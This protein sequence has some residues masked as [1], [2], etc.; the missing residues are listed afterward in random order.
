ME[1]IYHGDFIAKNHIGDIDFTEITGYA[2][3]T[4]WEG[5]AP[6]L[7]T[8]GGS[9]YF[10][11]WEGSAPKL[12]EKY[13]FSGIIGGRNAI[14]KFDRKDKKYWAGCFSGTGTE[15]IS[16]CTVRYGESHEYTRQYREFI[17]KCE[18]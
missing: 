1:N 10:T 15:L 12:S 6:E 7:H 3:F 5:S 13:I 8:I 11:G 4:G 9:A 16:A 17:Q 14:C 2:D 18:G